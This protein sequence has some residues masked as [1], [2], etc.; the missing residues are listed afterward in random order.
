MFLCYV[1]GRNVKLGKLKLEKFC[2]F[3]ICIWSFYRRLRGILLFRILVLE[4]SF[5][6]RKKESFDKDKRD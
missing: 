6:N 5:G 4:V 1:V 2:D 3:E